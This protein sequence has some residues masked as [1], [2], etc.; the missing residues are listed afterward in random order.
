MNVDILNQFLE[1]LGLD[2]IQEADDQLD[3][4]QIEEVKEAA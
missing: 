1:D 3:G 2:L 4:F